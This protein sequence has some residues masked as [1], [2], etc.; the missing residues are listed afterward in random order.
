MPAAELLMIA[1]RDRSA[2]GDCSRGERPFNIDDGPHDPGPHPD[3]AWVLDGPR[4]A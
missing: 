3:D 4:L 1:L 2:G